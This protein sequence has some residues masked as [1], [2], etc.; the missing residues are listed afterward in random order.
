MQGLRGRLNLGA[1]PTQERMHG[2]RENLHL[3]AQP[4]EELMQGPRGGLHLRAQLGPLW[5]TVCVCVYV[6]NFVLSMCV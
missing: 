5:E 4:Q 2:L 6:C 1:Q 3:R